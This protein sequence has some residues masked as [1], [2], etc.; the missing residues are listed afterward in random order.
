MAKNGIT[1]NAPEDSIT[2][3]ISSES[4]LNLDTQTQNKLIE[5]VHN[6]RE[7]DGGYMGK[8]LGTKPANVAMHI[9]LIICFLLIAI[10]IIDSVYSYTKGEGINLELVNII[11]PVVSLSLGYIFGKG[12]SQ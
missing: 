9:A 1:L 3:L 11:V 7:K 4:F 5:A 10:V 6:N 12:S 2:S 8:F